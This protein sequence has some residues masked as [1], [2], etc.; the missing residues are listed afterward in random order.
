M[1]GHM[2]KRGGGN[3]GRGST[4]PHLESDVSVF[5]WIIIFWDVCIRKK[6]I[7]LL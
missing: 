3:K 2:K 1:R 7:L 4:I 6:D 5:H